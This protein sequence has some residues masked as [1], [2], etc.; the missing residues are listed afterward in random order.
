MVIDKDTLDKILDILSLSKLQTSS[1]LLENSII[2]RNY[3]DISEVHLGPF[4]TSGM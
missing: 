2:K 4:Q 1:K 3:C